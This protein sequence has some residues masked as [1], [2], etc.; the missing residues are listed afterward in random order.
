M[1]RKKPRVF[2]ERW[3]L[4]C[5]SDW[6]TDGRVMIFKKD[7][8]SY[9]KDLDMLVDAGKPFHISQDSVLKFDFKEHDAGKLEKAEFSEFKFSGL[10]EKD[11]GDMIALFYSKSNKRHI[12]RFLW[13]MV[14]PFI[15]HGTKFEISAGH[16]MRVFDANGDKLALIMGRSGD[17]QNEYLSKLA[18]AS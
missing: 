18:V 2:L 11:Y 17:L 1:R 14:S 6:I 5:T 16:M 8:F 4:Q 7:Y 13:T 9:G 15:E 12:E 10:L 3:N